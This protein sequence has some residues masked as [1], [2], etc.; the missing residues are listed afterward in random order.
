LQ[1][2]ISVNWLPTHWALVAA[3][4][5]P[6][7]NAARMVEMV[8]GAVKFSDH[9]ILTKRSHTDNTL[10]FITDCSKQVLRKF[11][12]GNGLDNSA[13][14]RASLPRVSH[15]SYVNS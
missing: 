12:S 4:V 5:N 1:L 13:S 9:I 8:S 11:D 3:L 6:V 2:N 14:L 10:I 7:F 15:P